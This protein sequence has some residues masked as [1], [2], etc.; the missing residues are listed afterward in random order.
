MLASR[1]F[2]RVAQDYDSRIAC[3]R[4]WHFVKTLELKAVEKVFVDKADNKEFLDLGSGTGAG[5]QLIRRLGGQVLCVDIAP[6]MNRLAKAKGFEV[7]ESSIEELRLERK[8]DHVLA[9]GSFE[10][11][12]CLESCFKTASYHLQ[13]GGLLALLYPK[14]GFV[15]WCYEKL[16]RH[17]ECESTV[18]KHS[19][20]ILLAQNNGLAQV[21]RKL[22]TPMSQLMVFKKNGQ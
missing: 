18:A 6:E 17:W 10:F 12:S 16:H 5:A 22:V 2:N 8:F 9:L 4:L 3:N 7:F 21:C 11:T 20:L 15:G 1:Y 19:E 14:D 13:V